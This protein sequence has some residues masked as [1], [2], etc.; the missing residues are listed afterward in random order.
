VKRPAVLLV[1]QT[2]AVTA[3]L[4]CLCVL[5]ARHPWRLDLTPERRFTLSPHTRTVLARLDTDVRATA[6]Y[7]SQQGAVR[8]DMADLLAL[9]RDASP[10]VEVRFLDLDRSPGAAQRL[11]VDAY[12]VVVVEA[13]ERRERVD[14]LDEESVTAAIVAV[15]GTP[16]VPTYFVVGHGEHDPRDADARGG[17]TDAAHTLAADGFP[18]RVVEGAARLPADAGLVVLAGATRDLAPA[19]VDGLGRWVRD[20]GR[21]LLLADPG[22][23]A[24]VAGLL[25]GFGVELGGDVV[26]DEQGRLFGTDGLSARVAFLNQ[27]LVPDAPPVGALLPVAQTV[28]L[29]DAPDVRG[30]YLAMTPETTWADVDRRAQ[31]GGTPVFR[32]DVDRHGPLPVA[33][34]V[35]VHGASGREGRLA[36]VGD[37]DFVTNLHAN[38]LG[39]RDLLTAVAGLVGRDDVVVA[40][41]PP[42]PLSATFSPLALTDREARLVFWSAVVAPAATFM[43]AAFAAGRRRRLA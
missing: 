1:V 2:L 8:R 26:V 42:A 35:R 16:P 22:T 15:G 9:Y 39:N 27:T 3:I 23:P 29:V 28:R 11:D 17:A 43:L 10:H 6:F 4:A 7:S 37:A 21:L 19:E 12:N 32:P 25:R 24:S 30:D 34:F 20:G 14:V 38:V 41:R 31:A 33:A 36:V 5:A 40:A 18:V 13:G